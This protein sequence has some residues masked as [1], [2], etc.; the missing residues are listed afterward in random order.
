MPVGV[1]RIFTAILIVCAFYLSV[2]GVFAQEGPESVEASE[3]QAADAI[4]AAERAIQLGEGP[5][6]EPGNPASVWN[7]FRVLLTLAVVAA[8]IYGMVFF[9]KRA[10]KGKTASDPF[11]KVLANAQIGVNRSAYVLSVG[12]QAWLVGAAENGVS[13]IAEIGDKDALNAMLLAESEKSAQVLPG[14]FLDFKT[15]L[16]RLGMKAETNA[17]GPDNI[18]KRSERLKGL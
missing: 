16:G 8:A 17:P 10:A 1:F 7:I 12:T 6:P 4:T 14:R 9:I 18:R 15:L 11:L 3:T 2:P 5:V 13:L